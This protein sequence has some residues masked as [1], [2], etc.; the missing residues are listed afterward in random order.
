MKEFEDASTKLNLVSKEKTN[1]LKQLEEAMESASNIR[2]ELND[3]KS[4]L[5]TQKTNI[6]EVELE[7]LNLEEQIEIL[8]KNLNSI[9]AS[10]VE[11]EGMEIEIQSLM[12]EKDAIAI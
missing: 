4:E 1:L 7:K 11:K 12:N 8:Q 6:E 3:T 5:C 2:K 10:E 9:S